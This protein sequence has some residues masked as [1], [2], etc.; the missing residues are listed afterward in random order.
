MSSKRKYDSVSSAQEKPLGLMSLQELVALAGGQHW[1]E[2]DGPFPPVTRQD[3]SSGDSLADATRRQLNYWRT[4]IQER[5]ARGRPERANRPPRTDLERAVAAAGFQA[6]TEDDDPNLYVRQET[7][8]PH[9]ADRY[10]DLQLERYFESLARSRSAARRAPMAAAA[11][12]GAGG[13]AAAGAGAG[14]AAAAQAVVVVDSDDEDGTEDATDVDEPPVEVVAQRYQ[15]R[16]RGV[17]PSAQYPERHVLERGE[18]AGASRP[19]EYSR[20]RLAENADVHEFVLDDGETVGRPLTLNPHHRGPRNPARP[21]REPR[22]SAD[23]IVQELETTHAPCAE[24]RDEIVRVINQLKGA[25]QTLAI[26]RQ[27]VFR[28]QAD[29]A[30]FEMYNELAA[31]VARLEAELEELFRRCGFTS[32][33]ARSVFGRALKNKNLSAHKRRKYKLLFHLLSMSSYNH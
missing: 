23:M 27:G 3:A 26:Q 11:G 31:D 4:V 8:T 15:R 13:A 24:H 19:G 6:M 25:R 14:G 9:N 1:S 18:G 5:R 32:A 17:L 7:F 30:D 16:T 28:G 22:R 29:A 33:S 21:A 2:E 20:V 10:F 12:A